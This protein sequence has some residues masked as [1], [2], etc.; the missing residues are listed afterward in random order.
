M[1]GCEGS[2]LVGCTVVL[3]L[4]LGPGSGGNARVGGTSSKGVRGHRTQAVH[5]Q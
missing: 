5:V 3:S 2:G 4:V 1:S